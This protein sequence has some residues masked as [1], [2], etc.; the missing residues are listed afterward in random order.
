MTHA[1]RRGHTAAMRCRSLGRFPSCPYEGHS[2]Q[3]FAMQLE[4]MSGVFDAL[5]RHEPPHRRG[6][7]RAHRKVVRKRW[8]RSQY[9]RERLIQALT[10]T[11]R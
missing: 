4:F 7:V 10:T 8:P 6:T 11:V 9:A 1:Y 2:D 5:T 3:S